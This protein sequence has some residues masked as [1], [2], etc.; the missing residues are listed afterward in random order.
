MRG[1]RW[2]IL[3]LQTKV[4]IVCP[5]SF[6]FSTLCL[7]LLRF[8]CFLEL[9]PCWLFLVTHSLTKNALN[10]FWVPRVGNVDM[11]VEADLR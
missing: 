6:R 11:N 8:G 4:I 5:I 7:F 2:K 10:G 1:Y 9:A 3:V